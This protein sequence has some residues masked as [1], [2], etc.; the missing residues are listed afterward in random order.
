[1]Q[2]PALGLLETVD[3]EACVICNCSAKQGAHD[4]SCFDRDYRNSQEKLKQKFC[5]R[6]TTS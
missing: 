5:P 1:M 3:F 2:C 4:V 6:M